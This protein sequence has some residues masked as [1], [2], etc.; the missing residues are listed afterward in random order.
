MSTVEACAYNGTFTTTD[1]LAKYYAQNSEHLLMADYLVGAA[2]YFGLYSPIALGVGDVEDGGP[3]SNWMQLGPS[4]EQLFQTF[5]SNNNST[6]QPTVS[7]NQIQQLDSINAAAGVYWILH[8]TIDS[9]CSIPTNWKGAMDHLSAYNG[10]C[11][12]PSTNCSCVGGYYTEAYAW[13]VMWLA[14]GQ[15]YAVSSYG[16]SGAQ[17]ATSPIGT[18]PK[19][20]SE[21]CIESA[22]LTVPAID[23]G[24]TIR[25]TPYGSNGNGKQIVLLAKDNQDYISSLQISMNVIPGY[26]PVVTSDAHFAARSTQDPDICVIAVGGPSVTAINNSCSGLGLTC[27]S[28]SNFSAWELNQTSGFYGY[29]DASGQTASDSYTLANQDAQSAQNAGW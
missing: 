24:T 18:Q 19:Y 2:S 10:I 13:T 15:N 26:L 6:G 3:G 8:Q 16:Y 27:T 22:S 23:I 12:T 28:S 17:Y 4:A 1:T 5:W 11:E 21:A 29:I 14:Y 7:S 20:L 9:S 25:S